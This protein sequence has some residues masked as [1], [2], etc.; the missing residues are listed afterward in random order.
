MAH[1]FTP[2]SSSPRAGRFDL[3]SRAVIDARVELAACL[4]LA[5]TRPVRGHIWTAGCAA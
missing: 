4:Q 1:T 2:T 3:D 5:A